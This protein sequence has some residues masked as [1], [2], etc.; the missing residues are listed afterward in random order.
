MIGELSKLWSVSVSCCNVS[1]GNDQLNAEHV[2]A[3]HCD[4]ELSSACRENGIERP[5]LSNWTV[6]KIASDMCA[7]FSALHACCFESCFCLCLL[8]CLADLLLQQHAKCPVLLQLLH[9]LPCAV[10]MGSEAIWPGHPQ[11]PHG[12]TPDIELLKTGS[13]VFEAVVWCGPCANIDFTECF[14]NALTA[15]GL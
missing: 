10:Q 13:V 5:T 1:W 11:L 14:E 7:N 8:F 9:C 3:V 15:A 4:P 12:T 2:I 6:P